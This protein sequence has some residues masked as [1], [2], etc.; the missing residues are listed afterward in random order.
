MSSKEQ[1]QAVLLELVEQQGIRSQDQ[2]V[3][4]L[5][6]HGFS[7]TQAS[8]S[9]DIRELGLVK[10]G[11]RY[12][13]ITPPADAP[14][15]QSH[16]NADLPGLAISS[17]NSELITRCT[18]AG[19]NLLV[20]R[21]RVGAASIVAD[22]LDRTQLPEIVGTLAGDDTVFIAVSSRAAQGRVLAHLK[23]RPRP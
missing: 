18:P 19:A 11:G 20:L 12:V 1:R 23:A 6:E 5:K 21:T 17:H 3:A 4:L 14:G 22:Q 8:V 16:A 15:H 10:V 2:M 7:A 9:R 13:R